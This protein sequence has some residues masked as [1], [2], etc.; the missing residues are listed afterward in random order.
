MSIGRM[1]AK[2]I[3]DI[4]KLEGERG[5]AGGKVVSLKDAVAA[6]VKPG[7]MLHL[8]TGPYPNA[9]IREV[10]RQYR[11]Q[12]PA[13][14]LVTSGVATPFEVAFACSGLVKKVITTN[15]SYVYPTPRPISLLRKLHQAGKI[16]IEAWSLLAFEQRLQ[17]GAMGVG[18][19]PTRSMV[20]TTLAEDN[21]AAFTMVPDP[22][23]PEKKIG[24]VKAL[25]PDLSLI[26]GC[27]ADADGNAILAPPYFACLWGAKACRS[28]VILTVEKIVS[29]AFIRR[30]SA[31]VKIPAHLVSGLCEAPLGAHPQGL[32]AESIG[33]EGGYAEDYDFVRESVERSRNA[34]ELEG[35]LHEW[36]DRTGDNTGYLE[37]LGS[38]KI[39][40]LKGRSNADA[41]TFDMLG[42]T[43]DPDALGDC[44]ATETMTVAAARE[45]MDSIRHNGHQVMLAGIGTSGLAA[46]LAYYFLKKE[47]MNIDLMAGVGH[48]GSSPRP[49]D[50][51][52]MT[53]SNTMTC[54]MLTDTVE[55]YSTYVGG[56]HSRCLSVLGTA[57]VDQ[58]GNINTVK[59]GDTPFIGVGG[60]GDAVNAKETLVVAKQAKE[61]FFEKLPYIGC[62]GHSVK[63]LVTDFGVF[64]KLGNDDRFTLVKVILDRT[65]A[66][67]IEDAVNAIQDACGWP[68]V[69]VENP[70]AIEPPTADELAILRSLDP[71][72]MFIGK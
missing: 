7:M 71:D 58:Y 51:F 2:M 43:P 52:L 17:A 54:A 57:Q 66:T 44:N 24:A 1:V 18:F 59:I 34:E 14:T 29:K 67:G 31:L 32:A 23:E 20:G 12:N 62:S 36:V 13:F 37:K 65:D 19:L 33:I 63:T 72:R 68:V 9:L 46:W 39:F 70:S 61:R 48:L 38:E 49:G 35:W 15:H 28:G 53:L 10:I 42:K 22:F 5:K 6:N 60:A 55:I 26:H 3:N 50:P 45:I 64:K 27:V 11:G 4:F 40:F 8:N 41:W 21:A 16:E 25:V 56:A 30:N 69:S 47:G